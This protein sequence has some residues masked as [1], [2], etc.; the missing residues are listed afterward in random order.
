MVPDEQA[1]VARELVRAR[2]AVHDGARPL[3]SELGMSVEV[4]IALLV[5]R[6]ARRLRD[7]V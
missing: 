2:K 7:V 6:E 5:D 4:A 1:C 3:G